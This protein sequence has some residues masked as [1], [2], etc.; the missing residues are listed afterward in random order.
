MSNQFTRK[1][2]QA[3]VDYKLAMIAYLS[4]FDIHL[5]ENAPC[6]YPPALL[7]ALA[8]Y[9]DNNYIL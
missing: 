8:N 6:N 3:K 4:E 1:F 9:C 7:E 5:R 2:N